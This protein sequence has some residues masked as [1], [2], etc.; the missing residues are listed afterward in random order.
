[1]DFFVLCHEHNIQLK[2]KL[3]LPSKFQALLFHIRFINST[4]TSHNNQLAMGTSQKNQL[5][6]QN[7]S[8]HN[9][10]QVVHVSS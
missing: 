5:T 9:N 3:L 8:P 7:D 10:Q 1:M 6:V 2:H 4:A